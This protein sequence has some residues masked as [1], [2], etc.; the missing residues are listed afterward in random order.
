MSTTE[1]R[2]R[3]I[4]GKRRK[5]C[6]LSAGLVTAALLRTEMARQSSDERAVGQTSDWRDAHADLD[7][8]SKADSF[9]L[10]RSTTRPAAEA[11]P[12]SPPDPQAIQLNANG[13]FT[14]NIAK[15]TDILDTLRIIGFQAQKNILPSREVHGTLPALN[16]YNISV[17]KALDAILGTNGFAWREQD[18][19]IYVY[20]AAELAAMDK[21]KR[22][23]TT[24]VFRT[25]STPAANAVVMIKP[26]LSPEGQ[27]AITT[28]ANSGLDSGATN[29]GGNSHATE[30]ILV[31][32]DYPENLDQVRR[33]LKEIDKR[34]QQILIEATILRASL[35]EQNQFG[36]DFTALGGVDFSTLN[37]S[38]GGAGGSAS[39]GGLAGALSGTI[40][41]TPGTGAITDKGYIG[42]QVGGSGLMLGVVKNNIGA[43]ISALEGI[44]DTTILAN[45]KILALNKQKGEVI[46]GREDGYLTT[47]V[48]S[49]ASVQSVEFLQTG[50]RLIFRPY[51]ADEGYIRM[52]IHPEDSSGGLSSSN[53]PFKVTTE[54]TS[55]IMVKDGHTIVIGGL[56][57]E[58]TNTVKS[59]VP[60]LG[61]IPIAGYLF[62][63]QTDNTVR[64]EIIVLLTPHIVKDDDAYSEESEKVVADAERLR[65]GIRQGLMPFG[66]ERLAENDFERAVAELRK[67]NP[68]RQKAMWD[69]DCALN[70]NPKF[71]EA[72]KLKEQ[73]TGQIVTA[74]DNSSIRSFLRD[75]M[76]AQPK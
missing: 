26:V 42:T 74:S 75:Q 21:A 40:L 13:T 58:S 46:V 60:F 19:F 10:V 25:Y 56:F 36:V 24:E 35:N 1:S 16:L 37:N 17:P 20:T 54:V 14:L 3:T 2:S 30:D 11:L 7:V 70:L 43:F 65:V 49:T 73:L 15:D 55:N 44:T 22:H 72:I 59:Q 8:W 29:T 67:P 41:S 4:R 48:T 32:S 12:P 6:F 34:P 68:D 18:G 28:P 31:V 53:L 9:S 27:V 23:T 52:E 45:P 38:G 69:L 71:L 66:R 76:L 64:E 63:S 51:I 62:R 57:R 47:T 5:L 61:N 50:T 33:V 39:G